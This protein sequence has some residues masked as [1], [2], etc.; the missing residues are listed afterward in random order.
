MKSKKLFITGIIVANVVAWSVLGFHRTTGATQ[1]S[2]QQPF[3]NSV[4]Q[5]RAMIRELQSIRQLLQEQKVLLQQ[6]NT[7]LKQSSGV[8]QPNA[9]T[10]APRR[11]R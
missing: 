7:L 6:Q 11:L 1:K 9:T 5:R 10:P 8:K 4:E 2:V 3:A